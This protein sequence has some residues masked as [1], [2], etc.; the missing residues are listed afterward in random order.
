MM[1]LNGSFQPKYSELYTAK[2]K[3]EHL[4][5]LSL[6]MNKS[7]RILSKQPEEYSGGNA[8]GQEGGMYKGVGYVVNI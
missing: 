1:P 5:Q 8:M 4:A 7:F 6:D 3:Y 2:S